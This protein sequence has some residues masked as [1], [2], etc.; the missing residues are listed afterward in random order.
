MAAASEPHGVA[1]VSHTLL[2]FVLPLLLAFTAIPLQTLLQNL[3]VVLGDVVELILVL[4]TFLLRLLARMLRAAMEVA[5]RIYD[6][7][8]FIP[9]WLEARITAWRNTT[10]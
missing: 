3:Q 10:D 7:V 2:G 9:L 4:L 8:I 5:V 6:L 1:V